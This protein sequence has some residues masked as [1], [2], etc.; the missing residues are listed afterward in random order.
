VTDVVVERASAEK[1]HDFAV[2]VL[3]GLGMPSDD[4]QSCAD[5]LVWSELRGAWKHGV[6]GRLPAIVARVRAGNVNV[7]PSCAILQESAAFTLLDGGGGWGQVVGTRGMRLAIAK[8]RAT[9]VGITIVRNSEVTAALGWYPTVAVRERMIGMVINNSI[10]LMPAW[11]GSTRVIGNQA[12]A[13]GC[14]AARHGAMLFDS[15]V[16]AMSN[17]GIELVKDRGEQL[18]QG[19]ALDAAGRPT[20]DPEKALAG[21]ILPM[22]GY[23]GYGL[24]LMWEVLT[25]ILS[26]GMSPPEAAPRSSM[27]ISLFLMAIDPSRSMPYERFVERVD[28]LIDRMHA[29]PPAAGTDHVRVP[30]ERGL[31]L[32]AQHARSG[33]PVPPERVAKLRALGSELGVAW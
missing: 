8:A 31:R 18:P 3:R 27:G 24:A 28:G 29:S 15:T 4:A 14:P 7:T 13:I 2:G 17:N 26:G 1:L 21:L 20:L 33:V 32:E 25:G 22:G 9:G 30:G 10:P 6:T 23:R 5:A 11:G 19:V 16:A 12:F